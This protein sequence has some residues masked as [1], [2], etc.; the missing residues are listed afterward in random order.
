MGINIATPL[1]GPSPGN[2]PTMV[3]MT[4]PITA[5]IKL[6]GVSATAKPLANNENTSTNRITRLGF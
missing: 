4:Q 6:V 1:D 3:P 5:R 2:A